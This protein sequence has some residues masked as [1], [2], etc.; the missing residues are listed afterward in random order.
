MR[1]FTGLAL[2][3]IITFSAC[4]SPYKKVENGYEYKTFSNSDGKK[5]LYGNF[6]EF[7]IKQMYVNGKTDTL[8]GDSRDYMP[9]I[10]PYDSINLPAAYFIIFSSAKKGDSIV[11]RI[12]TDSAYRGTSDQMPPYMHKGGYVYST[13][14][15]LNIFESRGQ[16]DSANRAE[17]RLN[18]LKIYTKQL[19]IFEKEI[20][21]DKARIEAD[22]RLISAWLDKN[23]IKYTR[24]KWGSFIVIHDEGNGD[25]IVYNSVVSLNYTGKTLDSGKVF[26]SNMDPALA[27]NY[28]E[29]FEVTMSH[30]GSV[31]P[32]LIDGLMQLR[33]G[34]KAT[35][36]IPSS[37]AFGKKGN[38]GKIK[39]NEN[40]IFE[41]EVR[42]VMTEDQVLE[43]VNEKRRKTEAA[44]QKMADSLKRSR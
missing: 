28:K 9:R 14:K 43:I 38:T 2:L 4:N 26:D 39:P 7:H 11:I 21:K 29:P 35:I 44:M 13:I 12:P 22:S 8:L 16:A 1:Y 3:C 15:M 36:Y 5:L 30:I 19:N 37:L 34:A 24:G 6:M 33:N 27:Y 32:G 31:I 18:G 25:K 40:I 20:E 41:I 17:L 23:N 10:E 42:N